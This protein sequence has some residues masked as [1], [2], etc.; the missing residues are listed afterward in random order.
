MPLT[1]RGLHAL[2]KVHKASL[3]PPVGG[4]Q[5]PNCDSPELPGLAFSRPKKNQI[6]LFF[7]VVGFDIFENLLSSWPFLTVYR[8][9]YSKIPKFSFLRTEFVIFS[10]KHLATL[11]VTIHIWLK[12]RGHIAAV[13]ITIIHFGSHVR[14]SYGHWSLRP[15]VPNWWFL[16]NES[17]GHML[18]S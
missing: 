6:W 1:V 12:G 3:G 14:L 4:N 16:I 7:K 15:Y 18:A 10:Y 13:V 8:N 5:M 2:E 11:E 17:S 9:F